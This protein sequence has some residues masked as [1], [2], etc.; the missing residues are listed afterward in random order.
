MHVTDPDLFETNQPEDRVIA[1]N[2]AQYFS[3]V[4]QAHGE[5]SQ[6]TE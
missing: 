5:F 4:N 3:C 2:A 6:D 1:V